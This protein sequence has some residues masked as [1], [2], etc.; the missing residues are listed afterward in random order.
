MNKKLV[1]Q[2]LAFLL[3]TLLLSGCYQSTVTPPPTPPCPSWGCGTYVPFEP[4]VTTT[5]IQTPLPPTS[6]PNP[7]ELLTAAPILPTVEAKPL[8]CTY[9]V[10]ANEHSTAQSFLDTGLDLVAGETLIIEASG[11][12][13]FD[14]QFNLCTGPNGNPDFI[15]TDLVGRIGDGKMFHIGSSLEKT[16]SDEVGRLYL[17]FHDNDFENNSGYFDVTIN[18]VNSQTKICPQQ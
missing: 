6:T 14:V 10:N 3:F 18:V 11:T 9:R 7:T 15:D 2:T 5:P 1:Q 8:V 17:A 13:C 12:A 16:V 4:T